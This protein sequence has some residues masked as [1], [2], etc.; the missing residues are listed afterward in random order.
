MQ[1]SLNQMVASVRRGDI[2]P[3]DASR[4]IHGCAALLGLQ[5]AEDIPETTL[6]V[7]GMRKSA[8][9]DDFIAGFKKF[10]EI[11]S[12]ALSSNQRGFGKR[13]YYFIFII[14]QNPTFHALSFI[15]LFVL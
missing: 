5:L 12:A 3:E 9:R 2:T 8:S 15:L 11:D 7:T 1:E 10:G 14:L 4:I 13:L 6:I